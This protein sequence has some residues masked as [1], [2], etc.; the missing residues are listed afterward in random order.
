MPRRVVVTG[1]GI[2]SPLGRGLG[3]NWEDGLLKSRS[4]IRAIPYFDTADF[5]VKI[6]GIVPWGDKEGEFDPLSVIE[7]KEVKKMDRFIQYGIAAAVDAVAD[8]GLELSEAEKER[9][10]VMIGAGIGGLHTI[11]ET[12]LGLLESWGER[13]STKVSPFFIPA[14]L[15]NLTSGHVSIKFG[16]KGPNHSCVTACA[17]GTHSVGDAARAIILG[18]ADIMLA[19]GA[20][21][22][23]C[24]LGVA[25]FASAKTLSTRNDEP[26]R[27]SRPWD[28]GRDGFVIGEGSGV[29]VLEEYE[30]AKKRGA[31][32]YAEVIGYGM[33][34]DAYHMTAPAP[35]GGGGERAMRRALEVAGIA[36]DEVDYLNAHGTSTPMG[37]MLEFGAVAR[38]F[39]G[40][41]DKVSMSS[42]KSA[43]GHLLGAAGA[44]EAIYCILAMRDGTVPPTL[45]LDDP[46]EEAKGMDLVPFAA[47]QRKVS[48]A[49]S[50]SF[51]F[52]GT[53]ATVI[54]KRL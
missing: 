13:H 12:S 30:R 54:F 22:A 52:G 27:A 10:G 8:A 28:K 3:A 51:G 42:T 41:L 18:D 6:G 4:G 44:I 25:G 46:E 17:T 47:R 50:N 26:E 1:L 20:E 35:D 39:G 16:L 14:A 23:V 24:P 31:R 45:N 49:A 2:V 33:S 21:A 32:I 37:D 19:G 40:C 29:L 11:Y 48:I 53:N 36:P 9:T 5:P 7:A 34:G 15:I 43:T 38:V